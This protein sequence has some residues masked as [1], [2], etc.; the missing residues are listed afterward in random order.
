MR[1][2]VWMGFMLELQGKGVSRQF[3]VGSR[4]FAMG[5]LRIEEIIVIL[6]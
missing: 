1:S 4:Q 6:R 3:A 5:G 2:I